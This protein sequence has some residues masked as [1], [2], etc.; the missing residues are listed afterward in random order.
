MN[1]FSSAITNFT[2]K[3]RSFSETLEVE[4]LRKLNLRVPTARRR[5][6]GIPLHLV[7]LTVSQ[8]G[9]I[10]RVPTGDEFYRGHVGDVASSR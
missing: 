3:L 7:N 8:I 10:N 1:H 6:G 4:Q 5:Y 2:T 9:V